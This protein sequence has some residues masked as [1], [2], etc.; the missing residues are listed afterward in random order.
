LIGTRRAGDLL[1]GGLGNDT[2]N[3]GAG[4]DTVDGG[5]GTDVHLDVRGS[6]LGDTV[7]D[8]P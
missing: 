1:V 7:I 5:A 2:F 3:S 4:A 8:I 6:A